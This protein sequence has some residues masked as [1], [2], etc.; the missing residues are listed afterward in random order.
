MTLSHSEGL[1][2]IKL[3]VSYVC[4][5]G[6]TSYRSQGVF[7]PCAREINCDTCGQKAERYFDNQLQKHAER[8]KHIRRAGQYLEDGDTHRAGQWLKELP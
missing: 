5:K 1:M 3:S 6:H 4:V 2:G 8:C 7:Q